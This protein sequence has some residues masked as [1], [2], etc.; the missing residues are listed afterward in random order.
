MQRGNAKEFYWRESLVSE[1][2]GS[3]DMMSLQLC[4]M[5][6]ELGIRER[7]IYQS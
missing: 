6:L 3:Y 5:V 2:V 7:I 4:D 1:W